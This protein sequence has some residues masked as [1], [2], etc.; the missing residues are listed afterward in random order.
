MSEITPELV[1]A[2]VCE[3]GFG[4][5]ESLQAALS[6]TS[7]GNVLSLDVARWDGENDAEVVRPFRAVVVEGETAPIVLSRPVLEDTLEFEG[8]ALADD[9]ELGWQVV[10][11]S[12][13]QK[14]SCFLREA[15]GILFRGQ[16]PHISFA[17][18]RRFAAALV[19]MADAAE[20]SQAVQNGGQS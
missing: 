7:T 20:T 5:I 18:A 11:Y 17:E 14:R 19:A 4:W 10:P 9:D 3:G 2:A 1:A 8:G 15:D 13:G 16:D 12:S 6:V